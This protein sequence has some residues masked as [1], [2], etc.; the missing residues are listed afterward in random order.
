MLSVNQP[1]AQ[2]WLSQADKGTRTLAYTWELIRVGNAL[3]GINTGRPNRLGTTRSPATSSPSSPACFDAA[4]ALRPKSRIDL[5]LE[6]PGRPTCLVEVKNVTMRRSLGDG[7]PV[8]FPDLGY[9]ARRQT[10]RRA[11]DGGETGSQ[12][13]HAVY[14]AEVGLDRLVPRGTSMRRTAERSWP[15]P[16]RGSK[17]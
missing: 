8:E 1:G 13:R 15:R 6:Q 14:R 17:A 3:V 12:G 16:R 11:L 5:L 4:G 7:A 2:V 9:T 10:S